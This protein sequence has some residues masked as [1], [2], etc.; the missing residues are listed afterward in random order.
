MASESIFTGK[1]VDEAIAD[2]L[3]ALGLTADS[4]EI[5]IINRGSLGT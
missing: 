3:R 1:S 5:E 4:A 2:G